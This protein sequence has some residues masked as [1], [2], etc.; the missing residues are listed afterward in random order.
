MQ[1]HK[2]FRD[3]TRPPRTSTEPATLTRARCR[4]ARPRFADA[5]PTPRLDPDDGV[6][7]ARR[8][9]KMTRQAERA[10][11]ATDV[12]RLRR[13]RTKCQALLT[14]IKQTRRQFARLVY[15]IWK[16]GCFWHAPTAVNPPPRTRGRGAHPAATRHPGGAAA[17]RHH[18]THGRAWL[19]PRLAD[20]QQTELAPRCK[21][22]HVG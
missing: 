18:V 9:T 16:R 20:N 17:P 3:G 4:L 5:P 11:H 10:G 2:E 21:Y 19:S 7:P 8:S 13:C 12:A 6:A 22:G 1:N 15:N 14:Q